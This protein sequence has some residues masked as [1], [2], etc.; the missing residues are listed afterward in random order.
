MQPS[1]CPIDSQ[2]AGPCVA[3]LDS[4]VEEPFEHCALDSFVGFV[5]S[6]VCAGEPSASATSMHTSIIAVWMSHFIYEGYLVFSRPISI[7]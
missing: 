7:V 6:C 2:S 4:T 3:S 1:T 5:A